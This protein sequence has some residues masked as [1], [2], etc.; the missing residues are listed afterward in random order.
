MSKLIREFEIDVQ[1]AALLRSKLHRAEQG[2]LLLTSGHQILL[3]DLK[4]GSIQVLGDGY[5]MPAGI[6]VTGDGR[7]LIIA[8]LDPAQRDFVL[9]EASLEDASR[10]RSRPILQAAGLPMQLALR[11]TQLYYVDR[12]GGRVVGLDLVTQK[13]ETVLSSLASP[14][15]IL[16]DISSDCLY[17]SESGAG[18]IVSFIP[19]ESGRNVERLGLSAPQYLSF[20]S[21]SKGILIP[22]HQATGFI[23]SWNPSNGKVSTVLKTAAEDQPLAAWEIG[24]LMIVVDRTGI[25]WWDPLAVPSA[26][27]TLV[28]DTMEPFIGSYLR[29][30]V[31]LG[32]SGLTFDDLDFQLPD[33]DAAGLISYAQDEESGPNEVMLLV[34]YQ[35]GNHTLLAVDRATSSIVA[36]FDFKITER[37]T[38]PDQSPPHWSVGEL[39]NFTTGYTWGGGPAGPQNVDVIP[40]LGTRN[41]CILMVDVTDALYPTGTTFDTLRTH[42]KDDTV[43]PAPGLSARTYFEE[44]SY[45]GLT[46]ALVS[47]DPQRIDLTSA[48]ADNF[49]AMPSP[50]PS[51]SFQPTNNIAF[52]Q[53]CISAAAALTDGSGNRLINFQQVQSLILVI[54]SAGSATTN[55]FFWPQAWGGSFTVPGGSVN[56][57]VLGMPDDWD[58]VRGAR[59]IPETI[60]HELGHNLGYPDLYTNANTLYTPAVQA[61][62]ITNYDLMSSDGELPHVS[63]VQRLETGWVRPSWV[64]PFDFS[65]STIPLDQTITLHAVELGAPPTGRF[66]AAEVRIADGWNYYFEYRKTQTSQIGDQLLSSNPGDTI[67]GAILGTDAI[68]QSFTFPI[69]RPQVMRLRRDAENENSFFTTGQDYKETDASSMAIADF[70]M[71]VVSTGS[72]N[73]QI[74]IQYGTNGRPDIYIRPWPGGDNWQSPDIEVRNARSMADPANWFN[75]PWVGHAN[76]VIARYHNRGPVTCSNVRVDFYVKDYTVSGGPE[77]WIGGENRNIPPENSNPFVEFRASWIPPNDG[78]RCIIVRTGLYIDTSVNPNIVEITDT[79]NS[80]QSNYSRFIAASSSPARR[81]IFDVTLHNPF[82]KRSEIYVVPQIRGT[83]SYLYRLYMEHASLKLDP[84]ESRKV[85]IMVESMYG[86]PRLAGLWDQLGQKLFSEQ[87]RIALVGYGIPADTPAHPVL[88]GGA[89][90]DVSSANATRFESFGG[91]L[92]EGIVRGRV[93]TTKGAPAPGIVLLTFHGQDESIDN[94]IR[95]P[96]DPQGY[97]LLRGAYEFIDKFGAKRISGHYPGRPAYAP[98]DPDEDI[99]L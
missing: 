6:A 37:W 60:S 53:A 41:L 13:Y 59:T 15:G 33:G 97:F 65:R 99:E 29:I 19:G 89:Q 55:N 98:C 4:D 57:N 1:G 46:L 68:S 47:G 31:D 48:W 35:P 2:G 96:L 64:M 14:M 20:S 71:S 94:T 40:Q 27:L 93:V 43:A 88:L 38:D 51:N 69:A 74:R 49:T 66:A 85:R 11:G 26:P 17:V 9:Y 63:V 95:V 77:V 42:W 21:R 73:A 72:D 56:L 79:N 87:T 25:H 50:W 34:G 28:A 78:H 62:D 70:R 83:Y 3:Q 22:Q 24:E 92:Q 45:G 23:Q 10:E 5:D 12:L 76:E 90:L 32:T 39:S 75:V 8:D 84:G 36:T 44:V 30:T 18:R 67:D 52:A 86:D 81:G 58:T 61:R 16:A 80:A 91:D 7:S 54:R 82:D